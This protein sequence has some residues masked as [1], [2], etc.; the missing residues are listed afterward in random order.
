M[1]VGKLF[2]SLFYLYVAAMGQEQ[3]SAGKLRSKG[4]EAFIAGKYDEARKYYGDAIALEPQN[5]IN[6]FKLF[7]VHQRMRRYAEALNNLSRALELNP[8]STDYRLQKVKLLKSLGQCEEAVVVMQP[9]KGEAS[10]H[11]D[12]M[13]QVKACADDVR[14]AQQ[15][16]YAQ[17]WKEA[18]I[19]LDRALRHVEQATDLTFQRAQAMFH[20]A[21]YYGTIS[22][23]GRILKVH[24]NHLE[25]YE[26]RGNAYFRLGDHSTAL[27]HYRE[28]LKLDPEHKGCKSGH[29]TIKAMEKKRKRA[30]DAYASGKY[31][32]AIDNW[33]QAIQ[34]DQSHMAFIQPI[35]LQIVKAYTQLGQHNLAIAEAN[36]H[37]T[38]AETLEGLYA[39]GDAHIGAEK[40][41]DAM[42]TFRRAIDIAV[43]CFQS[44]KKSQ[45]ECVLV[46][47]L[48]HI[49]PNFFL[50]SPVI[51]YFTARG[52]KTRSATKIP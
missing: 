11:Q 32:E 20:T 25:A 39:L 31:Q 14:S 46:L 18:I 44:K 1:T 12:L 33:S 23:L 8:Q 21:D 45:T 10:I 48:C 36:K 35:R 4:E 43:C 24:P 5:A 28:G 51:L 16:M 30:E 38:F 41:Q 50:L 19:H 2:V 7:R 37:I 26:L 9:L 49:L 42:N 6:H 52:S 13:A 3:H 17:K 22:D 47:V 34:I 29:K 40:Y 15:M 27:T